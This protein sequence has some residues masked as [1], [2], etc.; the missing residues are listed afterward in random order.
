MI[1]CFHSSGTLLVSSDFLKR[2]VRGQA[3]ISAQDFKT[4]Q[5][6]SSSPVRY[7]PYF[8]PVSCSLIVVH[9]QKEKGPAVAKAVEGCRLKGLKVVV[10]NGLQSNKVAMEGS[11][12]HRQIHPRNGIGLIGDC[13]WAGGTDT[14]ELVLWLGREVMVQRI[15]W[16]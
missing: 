8:L 4:N 7:L 13:T 1:A 2:T 3:R 6:T 10:S 16:R 15:Y 12:Y 9:L 11:T 5:S 14:N